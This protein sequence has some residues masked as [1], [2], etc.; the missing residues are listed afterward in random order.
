[1]VEQIEK[2]KPKIEEKKD[3]WKRIVKLIR[4]KPEAKPEELKK[5]LALLPEQVFPY[6]KVGRPKRTYKR[7]IP[8]QQYRQLLARQKAYQ[9]LIQQQAIQTGQILPEEA[10]LLTEMPSEPQKKPI[11]TVFR[12]F[13]GKPYP[14]VETRPLASPREGDYYEDVDLMTGRR[15]LRRRLPAEAWIAGR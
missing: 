13:G 15:F 5:R 7:G 14:P 11:G 2:A 9:R 3:L 4:K 8:A 6:T 1:M 12:S 10:E